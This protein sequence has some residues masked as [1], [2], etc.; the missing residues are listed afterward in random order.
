VHLKL[1]E[2]RTANVPARRNRLG[3]MR[4]GIF[5]FVFLAWAAGLNG[6]AAAGP[7]QGTV[8]L[9]QVASL[10]GTE[11]LAPVYFTP[12]SP[13]VRVG[14]ISATIRFE[15]KSVSFV[16]AEKG[17]QLDSTNGTFEVKVDEDPKNTG[18]SILHLQVT[19]GAGERFRDGL[20]IFLRF[21]IKSDAP[22]GATITLKL[23]DVDAR[24][25]ETPP[26]PVTPLAAKNGTIQVDKPD[27]VPYTA[28][29][30]FS[31]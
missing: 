11:V 3:K 22:A 9:G 31:H 5:L 18:Q 29:F 8:S 2:R 15:N 30:F 13:Q 16:R 1:S 21:A 20:L 12:S 10:P 6:W 28:C 4:G 25:V 19:A 26:R 14:G 24:D 17:I 7:E 23:G 27:D